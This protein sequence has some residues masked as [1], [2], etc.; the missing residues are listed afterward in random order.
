MFT[1]QLAL[2]PAITGIAAGVAGAFVR[3][4]MLEIPAACS[5]SFFI[6]SCSLAV[7][8]CLRVCGFFGSVV[9]LIAGLRNDCPASSARNFCVVVR[10]GGT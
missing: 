8:S 3:T 6:S 1:V 9:A 4:L 7:I 10:V 5:I 2:P